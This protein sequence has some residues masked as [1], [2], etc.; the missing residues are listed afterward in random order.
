M[1]LTILDIYF[2]SVVFVVDFIALFA[3]DSL[4]VWWCCSR[5]VAILSICC[6]CVRRSIYD[7]MISRWLFYIMFLLMCMPSFIA[8]TYFLT[9]LCWVVSGGLFSSWQSGWFI[10]I[11]YVVF[12]TVIEALT[13]LVWRQEEHLAIKKLEWWGAGVVICLERGAYDQHMV[14]L[15]PLPPLPSLLQKIQNGLFFCPGCT[16]IRATK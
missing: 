2:V 1:L 3:S 4:P 13:L 6:C 7:I 12:L 9:V 14:G 11:I 8:R 16:G 5:N 15:M 10:S